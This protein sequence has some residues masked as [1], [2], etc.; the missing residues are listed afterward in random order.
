MVTSGPPLPLC[1]LVIRQ[2]RGEVAVVKRQQLLT[3]QFPNV[4]KAVRKGCR[5]LAS[6]IL[7]SHSY[8]LHEYLD[9][10]TL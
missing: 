3:W 8:H 4:A 6:P 7:D 2:D 10:P 5:S 9:S 1:S